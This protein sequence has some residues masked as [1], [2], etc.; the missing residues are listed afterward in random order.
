[1]S[2]SK[3]IS[4]IPLKAS[5]LATWLK[6]AT[7]SQQVWVKDHGFKADVGE[8]L[9]VPSKNGDV[10]G[11]LW[12]VPNDGLPSDPWAYAKL[13]DSLPIATYSLPDSL[14]ASRAFN[15]VFG[16]SLASYS[17][18]S[19]KSDKPKKKALL[20]QPKGLDKKKLKAIL[21]S[22]ILVRDL[23][24]T[25]TS[26]ML[27]SNLAASANKI[28]KTY[29][30]TFKTIVGNKL[31]DKNL[32]TIHAVGRASSDAP[33]LIDISWGK[34]SHPK[35]TLVG[36]GVCF[37]SGGLGIKPSG[38]MR[39]MKKDMGGAA[40]VLG[41]ANAIMALGLPV[42]LR[43]LIP[44]VEN[45][46]SANAF[47]PGD[48]IKT[49]KGI[50][51]EVGHTDAEGRLVLCDALALA[52]EEA[53]DLLLDFATLTGAARV[54]LGPDLP[55]LFTDDK[56]LA[57]ELLKAGVDNHD[58]MWQL[59]IWQ[60]YSDD[61][62]SSVADINNISETGFAGATIGALFLDRFVDKAKS[63]AH[64]DI[65]A[66]NPASKPGKPKGGEAMALRAALAVIE[67]KFC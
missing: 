47:R 31:L 23:V 35:V 20:K 40:H 54:A 3:I 29:K 51:V 21:D 22:T 42:R 18:A 30:A 66:W 27:P 15:A 25:P 6:K 7:S 14:G 4:I 28:A 52:D 59:P 10:E 16:W 62:K 11:V 67:Q 64:F 38:G 17:F 1:M 58:P 34:K 2:K 46:I 39:N 49:R 36:K 61:L 45:A 50:T 8:Y 57:Q 19:F 56:K 9:S 65:F 44:A 55:A 48:V 5:E 41:L 53:P 12:G 26:H 60:G 63:W 43:V 32:P 37:D 24:N 13:A 33:R